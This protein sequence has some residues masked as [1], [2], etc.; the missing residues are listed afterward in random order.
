MTTIYW[1]RH[2]QSLGNLERRFL[3][4]TDLPL[5]DHGRRQADAAADYLA[6]RGIDRIYS[7]DLLRARQT[8]E[9]LAERLGLT[10]HTLDSLREIDAGLWEGQTF[11]EILCRWGEDYHLFRADIGIST[12]TGGESTQHAADR[13]FAAATAL[14]EKEAGHTLLVTSHA[15]VTCMFT[16]RVLGL[17][18]A[19]VKRLRLPSNASL[20]VFEHD[21]AAFH[22]VQYGNDG[23]LGDLRLA[24]PPTV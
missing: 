23:Y 13:V 2:G 22:L 12:P 19:E 15:A 10:V 3:G 21:G 6:S 14:A 18:P 20:S 1:L 7:S 9:P 17:A 8:A 16:A 24:P 11:T 5:T 4:H